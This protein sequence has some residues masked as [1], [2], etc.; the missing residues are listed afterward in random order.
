MRPPSA[1]CSTSACGTLGPPALTRMASYGAYSRQPTVPSPS[2]IETLVAPARVDR[3]ARRREQRRNALDREDLRDEMREQHGLIARAGADLEHA[4]AALER[5]DLEVPRMDARL[6]DGL[7][8]ADRK[9]RIL[10]RAMAHAGGHERVPRRQVER[11]QHGEIADALLAQQLDEP[12]PRAAHLPVYSSRH[13]LPD[14]SSM[15]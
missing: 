1:S 2:S 8:A 10:V 4:L 7:P 14:D 15:L 13:Q 5:E 3:L 11:T 6:R 12:A 9:R